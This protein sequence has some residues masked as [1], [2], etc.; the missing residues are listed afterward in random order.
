MTTT[1]LAFLINRLNAYTP[2]RNMDEVLKVSA[3]DQ[4]IRMYRTTSNPP[5]AKKKSTLKVFTHVPLYPIPSDFAQL[6]ILDDPLTKDRDFGEHPRY[7]YTSVRDFLEDP[8]SG[9][10]TIAEVWESGSKSL[11][12]KNIS[13]SDMTEGMLDAAG[14]PAL[15][16]DTGDAGT[17]VL[18]EVLFLTGP[19]SIRVPVTFS[20]GTATVVDAYL[21][22]TTDADWKKKYF[23]RSVYFGTDVPT[24]LVVDLR[25]DA[26]DYVSSGALTTQFSGQPFKA[27]DWNL[28]GFDLNTATVTGTFA[29]TFNDERW[30]FTVTANGSYNFDESFLRGWIMQDLWYYMTSNVLT[31]ANAYQDFFAPDSATY[32]MAAV[33]LGDTNWHDFLVYEACTYLLSDEKEQAILQAVSA[34]RDRS[35]QNLLARYPDETPQ[36]STDVYRFSTDYQGEM[37]FPDNIINA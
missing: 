16:T 30:V 10:N 31:S 34:L 7:V 37:G 36:I 24:S 35:W 20:S 13:D 3:L 33:L 11:G 9:R 15:W 12:V 4:A 32:D 27:N 28:I 23:F 8:T 5:W 21:N 29:G 2:V 25:T 14:T 6:S 26:G 18:D 22:A 1:S 19:S 17:A